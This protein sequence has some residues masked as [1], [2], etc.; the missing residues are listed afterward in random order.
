MD[1]ALLQ[2]QLL[3]LEGQF[4]MAPPGSPQALTLQG[5]IAML[6]N[7]LSETPIVPPIFG[8]HPWNGGGG[9]HGGGGQHGGGRR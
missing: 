4:A 6:E 5:Q 1:R 8:P 3:E 7:E 2:A 9:T